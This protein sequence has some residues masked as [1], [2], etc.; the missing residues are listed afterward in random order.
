M[1][2]RNLSLLNIGMIAIGTLTSVNAQTQTVITEAAPTVTVVNRQPTVPVNQMNPATRNSP[3]ARPSVGSHPTQQRVH[4]VEPQQVTHQRMPAN[5]QIQTNTNNLP[6]HNA[7]E[8]PIQDL[9]VIPPNTPIMPNNAYQARSKI[10]VK[11]IEA[12]SQGTRL[13]G[14]IRGLGVDVY[15]FNAQQGQTVRIT[16]NNSN[17]AME[18]AI[19]RPTMGMRFGPVQVIPETGDY[20]LRIVQTRKD[21]A[22]NKTPRH[23]DITFQ[24]Q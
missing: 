20:E 12:S 22:R 14:Q 21:A 1:K 4:I 15:H 3:M 18:F 19:F 6:V 2:Y 7:N 5:T 17:P 9:S 10:P 23:Y 13:T 24:I 11:H 16:R 8:V